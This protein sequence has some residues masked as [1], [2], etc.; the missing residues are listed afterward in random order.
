[1]PALPASNSVPQNALPHPAADTVDLRQDSADFPKSAQACLSAFLDQLVETDVLI[2]RLSLDSESHTRYQLQFLSGVEEYRE[3]NS[4]LFDAISSLRALESK[5]AEQIGGVTHHVLTEHY[6]VDVQHVHLPSSS[7]DQYILRARLIEQVPMILDTLGL[8]NVELRHIRNA[9][10]ERRGMVSIGTPHS[11][12][13]EDWQRTICRELSAPDRSIVALAPRVLEPIPGVI[14]TELPPGE[15]WDQRLWQH[16]FAPDQL[17]VLAERCLIIQI[18]Q[19]P[20]IAAL[21]RRTPIGSNVH[22]LVMHQPMRRLCSACSEV[23][24]NPSRMDYSFLDRA[25]PT[26]SDGVNAW[27]SASQTMHF[28]KACGCDECA[29]TG[30]AGEV[31]IVDAVSDA[32]SIMQINESPDCPTMTLARTTKLVEKAR[33]GEL[34]LNEVRRVL[35]TP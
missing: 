34:C 17:G 3:E 25:L 9:L 32:E 14:Q 33:E 22:R 28:K 13:C 4:D 16:G 2:A 31:C 21:A 20:D 15:R 12:H 24:S 11:R 6:S 19:V 18:L 10:S 8:D 5:S 23:H 7:G 30:Y 26:L 29:S 27:L 35:T 1:M